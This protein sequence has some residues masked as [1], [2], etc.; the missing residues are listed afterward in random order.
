MKII[1]TVNAACHVRLNF[2]Y[3]ERKRANKVSLEPEKGKPMR[4][5]L[6]IMVSLFNQEIGKK[7][8]V[9]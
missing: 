9:S 5:L 6:V 2:A 3:K 1:E 7:Y 4:F 8:S